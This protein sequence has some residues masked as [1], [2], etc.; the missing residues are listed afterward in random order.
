[1]PKGRKILGS[2]I[3]SIDDIKDMLKLASE[4]NVRPVIQKLPMS[5]VNKGLD[6]VR[7]GSVRY[8]VVLEN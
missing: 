3:G 5:E 2:A 1:V 6:M 7:D 8:R 4:K